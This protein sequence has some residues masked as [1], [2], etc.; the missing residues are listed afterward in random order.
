MF[1]IKSEK[2]TG[3]Q[4]DGYMNGRARLMIFQIFFFVVKI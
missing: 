2:V 4:R 1:D 3:T